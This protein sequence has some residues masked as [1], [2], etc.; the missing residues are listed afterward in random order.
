MKHALER[1]ITDCGKNHSD[2][3]NMDIP[4]ISIEVT[5]DIAAKIRFMADS[6]VFAISTGNA[7]L[8]FHEG[9]LKSIKTEFFT[10]PKLSTG[11]PLT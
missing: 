1:Y 8:N 10:Y 11:D 5:P 9:I 6:G 4:L 3:N 2:L 7:S